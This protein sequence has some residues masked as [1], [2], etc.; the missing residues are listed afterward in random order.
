MVMA[1]YHGGGGGG[2]L[3]EGVG[4]PMAHVWMYEAE[5]LWEC[6]TDTWQCNA[7]VAGPF[8]AS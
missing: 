1:H 8:W 4:L 7:T 6:D 2:C 3:W 5:T